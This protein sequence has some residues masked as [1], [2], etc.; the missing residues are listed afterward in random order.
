MYG[1]CDVVFEEGVGHC[2]LD[3][4]PVSNEGEINYVVLQPANDV[5]LVPLGLIP[6]HANTGPIPPALPTPQHTTQDIQQSSCIRHPSQALLRSQDLERDVKEAANSGKEWTTNNALTSIL[7]TY[8]KP[9][10]LATIT[11]TSSL[12]DPENFWLPNSYS[13]AMTCMPR[14]MVSS[15]R[16]RVEGDGR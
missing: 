2:T 8:I 10:A 11:T 9:T 5:Q 12:P 1:S 13:E 4:P 6:A 7:S 15:D 14:H 16:K 3:T